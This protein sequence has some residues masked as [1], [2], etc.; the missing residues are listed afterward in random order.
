MS[1]LDLDEL[2]KV[3]V[4]TLIADEKYPVQDWENLHLPIQMQ[5]SENRKT[6][7]RIFCS[8]WGIYIKF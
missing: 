7:F 8:I 6:F 3:F 1:P 4:N 5:L 2:L